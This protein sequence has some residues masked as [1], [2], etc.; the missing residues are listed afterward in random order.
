MPIY[1]YQCS[2][3]GYKLDELQT[4]SEPPL[5]KCPNCGKDTLKRLIGA[6]A[7]IIFKGSGFYQTDYKSS[8]KETSK[9][10]SAKNKDSKIDVKSSDTKESKNTDNK[11][12]NS[13]TAESKST[14]SKPSASKP[15]NK[16]ENK[17]N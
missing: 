17:K 13:K 1:E 6:G 7:G 14:E 11:S 9:S 15:T 8:S 4:M 10:S 5:V 2:N 12:A 16:T 3:C